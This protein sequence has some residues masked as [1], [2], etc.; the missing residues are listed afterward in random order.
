MTENKPGILQSLF[1]FFNWEVTCECCGSRFDGANLPET[2]P[3]P[4][5]ML[6]TSISK[7]QTTENNLKNSLE[8]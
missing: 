1:K 2:T 3:A 4:Q 7:S 6:E 8:K 5:I